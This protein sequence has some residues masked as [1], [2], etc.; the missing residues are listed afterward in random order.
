[1]AD[2]REKIILGLD[3]GPFVRGLAKASTATK[4]FQKGLD[5]SD[6]RMGNL[7]QTSLALGPA[8]VPI[9]AAAVPAVAA[10]TAGL[11]AA[12][13]AAGVAALAFNGVGEGLGALND[14]QL[15]PSAKNL[16]KVRQAFEDLGPAGTNFVMFLDDLEPKLDKLQNTARAGLLPGVEDGIRSLMDR[17]PQVNRIIGEI[18]GALGDLAAEGGQN[19][20]GPKFR[21]FF[22][23]I[24]SE[25][26]PILMD[27]GR[28]LGNVVEGLSNMLVEFGP[29]SSGFSNGLLDMSR[30]FAKW[31]RG[32]ENNQGFQEFV[33]YV[34]RVGPKAVDAVGALVVALA[35]IVE[36][37]APVGEL[38]LPVIQAVARALSAIA[39]SPA[40][41]ALIAAAA[42]LSAISRAVALYNVTNGAAITGL[43]GKFAKAKIAAAGVGVLALSLTDLDD[44]LGVSNTAMGAAIGTLGGPWGIAIGAAI[45]G[46]IDFANRNDDVAASLDAVE[47]AAAN[48]ASLR[49]YSKA[50]D[51]AVKDTRKT[52]SDATNIDKFGDFTSPAEAWGFGVE[53]ITGDLDEAADKARDAQG[54]FND[55]R[56]TLG[57]IRGYVKG[58]GFDNLTFDLDTLQ[59]FARRAEPALRKMGYSLEDLRHVNTESEMRR[60]AAGIR[61]F[62]READS[63]PGRT[64]DVRDAIRLLDNPM[65]RAADGAEELDTAL[66]AL[67]D[68]Q[69]NAEEALIQWTQGIQELRK[70]FMRSGGSLNRFTKAGQENRLAAV[71]QIRT[72]KDLAVA[73]AE[74]DGNSKRATRT[75]KNTREAIIQA[76]V[77]AGRSRK[78]MAKYVN[79]LGLTPK[80]VRTSV[81]TPGLDKSHK[82]VSKFDK[83]VRNLLPFHD[84]KIDA[85]GAPKASEELKNVDGWVHTIQDRGKIDINTSAPGAKSTR[86][87]LQGVDSD[88]R[89]IDGKNVNVKLTAQ[90]ENVLNAAD[91]VWKQLGFADGGTVDF[92]AN[93]DVR[94]G[95]VA[96]IAPAGAMRVWA[97]PETGGEA[98]IPLASSKRKRSRAI[99]DETVSRLGG[100]TV[101]N[102]DGNIL[103]QANS[104]LKG[105][106]RQDAR[107]IDRE[108]E[109]LAESL[110]KGYSKL[111][112]QALES[113]NTGFH[114]PLPKQYSYSGSWGHYASGGSHPALDF[115]APRA[116]PIFA[117]LPGKVQHTTSLGDSYGNYTEISHGRGLSSLYAHQQRF[118]TKAGARV[119][120]GE[121][122]GYVNS[123]GNS[124]GDHL[125][126]E[127]QRNGNSFDF[128]NM[129]N[130]GAAFGFPGMYEGSHDGLNRAGP[131]KAKAYARSIMPRYGWKPFQWSYWNDLGNRESG[132]R[133]NATNP[134]SGAYGIP[135]SLPAEKMASSGPDWRTNVGTQLDWMAGYLSERYG[136]PYG[137][138]QHHNANN[139]YGDGGISLFDNGGVWRSGTLGMNASGRDEFVIGPEL[140]SLLKGLNKLL[141][142]DRGRSRTRNLLQPIDT[143]DPRRRRFEPPNL[144]RRAERELDRAE[145]RVK[146]AD[147]RAKALNRAIEQAEKRLKNAE[148]QVEKQE[149]QNRLRNLE[150]RLDRARKDRDRA[151]RDRTRAEEDRRTARQDQKALDKAFKRFDITGDMDRSEVRAEINELIGAVKDTLGKDSRLFKALD[152]FRERLQDAAKRLDEERKERQ[153]LND[154]L[155][156]TRQQQ[157]EFASSVASNFKN[158]PFTGG[159]DEFYLQTRADKNDA[160]RFNRLRGRGNRLGLDGPLMKAILASGNVELLAELVRGG[161]GEIRKAENAYERSRRAAN[162]LGDRSGQTVF[163]DEVRH[164]NRTIRHQNRLINKLE[165]RLEHIDKQVYKGARDGTRDGQDRK[166]KLLQQFTVEARG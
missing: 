32:L 22:D 122:I 49:A 95:H 17:A 24:E 39:E 140:T 146:R 159:L 7:V 87:E 72:A 160:Q 111:I 150:E 163:G 99:A 65:V 143:R 139:W 107:N 41:P 129:L 23:Y 154:E 162:Q 164:L 79:E 6:S 112:S 91:K 50:V 85:P 76:G 15:E 34:E 135:Q 68:P 52:L 123:T 102:A 116:T 110:T 57:E 86:G 155:K 77:A 66:T 141:R 115:P 106:P 81:E 114:W 31:S 3:A 18:S 88:I 64:K 147:G 37:A 48:P 61:H 153:K 1:M 59:K 83:L 40:G 10:L 27:M 165:R 54:R 9:G 137:A 100:Q 58:G 117:V 145:R 75:L 21:D 35:D 84:T 130:N 97:E 43:L 152:R 120:G 101:W 89:K 128:T 161:R 62:T 74:V 67:F 29:L 2:R 144:V 14:Y 4:A 47:R 11:G 118:A 90:A 113:L 131:A 78:D 119:A 12:A 149:A 108:F 55:F 73:Q 104:T 28:T 46:A 136:G 134:S 33:R 8:L 44:K 133:W 51:A 63:V 126:L 92:F 142:E 13:G 26:R 124:T 53:K 109:M 25:A 138:I 42:G 105:D 156:E 103:V 71:A 96:Q 20:A 94:N 5:S 60:L 82:D 19:L 69:L 148:G 151:E 30:E 70:Q 16:E 166:K 157:R 56:Q 127:M 121:T 80:V 158:D 36:A 132:W 98:Y 125:H 38:T 93:G 45:G